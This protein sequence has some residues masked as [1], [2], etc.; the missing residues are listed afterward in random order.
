MS[1]AVLDALTIGTVLGG[2]SG[3]RRAALHAWEAAR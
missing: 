2:K 1:S 3:A